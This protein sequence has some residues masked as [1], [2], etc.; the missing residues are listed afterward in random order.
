M[1]GGSPLQRVGVI[2][3]I[4]SEDHL[5][6]AALEFLAS[7]RLDLIMAVGDIVDGPGNLD[8]CC[9]LLQDYRVDTVAGNHERWILAGDARDLPDATPCDAI[10]NQTRSFLSNLPKTRSYKTVAGQLLLCHGLG[11]YDIGGV[12]PADEGYALEANIAFLRL[13]MESE[14]RFVV[15]GHTHRRMVRTFEDLTIVNAGTLFHRHNPCF[16]TADFQIGSV[17]FYDLG[18]RGQISK[19]E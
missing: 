9:R 5:L 13:M 1:S 3:D 16:L 6:E 12:W 10:S 18:G 14:Y 7:A 11:Q 19:G 8:E 2:G 4:H 15:N 17:Q